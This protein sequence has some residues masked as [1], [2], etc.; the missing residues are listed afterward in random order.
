MGRSK[1][2]LGAARDRAVAFLYEKAADGHRLTE[3]DWEHAMSESGYSRRQLKRLLDQQLSGQ[4]TESTT[5]RIDEQMITAVFL[6]TG[7]V[8]GAYTLLKEQ[9]GREDLP[10]VRHFLRVVNG[11]L[12]SLML[13]YAQGGAKKARDFKVYLATETVH[14][15]H[16]WELDHTELP[17]WVVPH[18]HK[19][20]VRPWLTVV[21]DRAARYPLS[22]VLTFG[23]PSV[24]EVRACLI[25]AMTL[26]T[27]PDGV[28]V[29]GGK[30][31]RTVWDRGLEFLARSITESCMR[32]GVIPI[33]LP[34]YSPHLK[35]HLERFWDFLKDRA[36]PPLPGYTDDV[37]DVRG[38]NAIADAC[39]GEA[40]FLLKLADWFD[41]YITKHVH[42]SLGCTPLEAWQRDTTPIVEV[43]PDRLW[44]DF[45]VAKKQVTVSKNGVRFETITFMAPELVGKVGRE[46]EVRYLPQDRSFIEVFCDG[47]HVCTA[48]S[49]KEL[50]ADQEQSVLEHRQAKMAEARARF[51]V[52]NR[53]RRTGHDSTTPLAS[54]KKGQM[55]VVEP[56]EADVDLL[57]GGDEAL[58]AL[59]G[60][61]SA[62]GQGSLW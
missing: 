5:F 36:L 54:N 51:T 43:S 55:V 7:N 44:E 28:T 27:A 60:V 9:M 37:S 39:L 50:S 2:E 34:A 49:R 23:R 14:R 31:L 18:G 35:P 56:Q 61:T 58:A 32:L 22:W 52:A 3:N 15:N 48:T 10:S 62:D 29:V 4:P 1:K 21:F 6:M 47:E 46:V 13:A 12:G 24:E 53:L 38:H 16:T 11:E 42:S 17:I 57:S 41:W 30:P 8:A 45:L 26:R 33:A 19:T 59:V 25:Q 40:E 20:A